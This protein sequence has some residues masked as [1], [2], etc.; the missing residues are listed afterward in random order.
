MG[1]ETTE[2]PMLGLFCFAGGVAMILPGASTA[3]CYGFGFDP[4]INGDAWA[5]ALIAMGGMCL[6]AYGVRLTKYGL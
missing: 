5:Q 3:F 1:P 2:R 6:S 4:I